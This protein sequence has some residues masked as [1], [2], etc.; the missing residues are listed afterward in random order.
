M[1]KSKKW[2]CTVKVEASCAKNLS[3][4]SGTFV[5]PDARKTFIKLRQ[6][7]FKA[8]ILNHFNPKRLI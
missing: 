7:F 8:F 6:I 2:I 5:T 1:L 3:S 4:K